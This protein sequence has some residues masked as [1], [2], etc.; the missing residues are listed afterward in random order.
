MFVSIAG[1]PKHIWPCLAKHRNACTNSNW[2]R[3][4]DEAMELLHCRGTAHSVLAA[5]AAAAALRVPLP[6]PATDKRCERSLLIALL[7]AAL[8]FQR[9]RCHS[10][11]TQEVAC[12]EIWREYFKVCSCRCHQMHFTLYSRTLLAR[13]PSWHSR[14]AVRTS[15]CAQ[16]CSISFR[17][18]SLLLT[19]EN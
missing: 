3:A 8:R 14:R 12:Y 5:A 7:A 6:S 2:G 1:R 18:R 16:L 11:S 19:C 10:R 4:G 17:L 13:A 9:R 15:C